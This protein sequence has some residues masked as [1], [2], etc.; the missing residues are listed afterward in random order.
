[1]VVLVELIAWIIQG[2]GSL[3]IRSRP[4]IDR[5]EGQIERREERE[6]TR[7]RQNEGK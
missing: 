4:D 1:M 3:M 2:I 7:R 5:I 6:R